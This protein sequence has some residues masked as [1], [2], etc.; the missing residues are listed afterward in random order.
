M[1]LIILAMY[2]NFVPYFLTIIRKLLQ[3]ENEKI[4]KDL[5]DYFSQT[6]YKN[7][8]ILRDENNKPSLLKPIQLINIME[9]LQI[10]KIAFD[11]LL[12]KKIISYYV[13]TSSEFEWLNKYINYKQINKKQTG[14]DKEVTKLQ[15]QQN[16]WNINQVKCQLLFIL[17]AKHLLIDCYQIDTG[18]LN[19]QFYLINQ[20][21]EEIMM[22]ENI[23]P[24]LAD[25]R[26][27]YLAQ[28]IIFIELQ[29]TQ[30]II[31]HILKNQSQIMQH[32]V[33]TL[34]KQLKQQQDHKI[35]SL[36]WI[37]QVIY[38]QRCILSIK[39]VGI[40]HFQQ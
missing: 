32:S 40:F 2:A 24:L 39:T 7:V 28:I 34:L 6:E 21:Q 22:I 1:I 20:D 30:P 4:V 9:M 16:Y 8:E 15:L 3:K 31:H 5:G 19:N 25:Q 13:Q 10:V 29:L 38:F 11:I 12:I 17:D 33:N 23:Y 37:Q 14:L 27:K 35:K 18:N 26:D 36:F